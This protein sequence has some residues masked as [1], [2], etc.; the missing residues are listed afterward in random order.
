MFVNRANDFGLGGH[1]ARIT[2][3]L[4]QT[5]QGG[6][7][8][9]LLLGQFLLR[10]DAQEQLLRALKLGQCLFKMSLTLQT[11]AEPL[12]RGCIVRVEFDC[13]LEL[14]HCGRELQI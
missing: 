6:Q 13:P 10:L 2:T 8:V 11:L 12:M 7:K 9:E 5:E 4:A 3:N 1:Q 14:R